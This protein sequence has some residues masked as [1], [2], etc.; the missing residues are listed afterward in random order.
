[1]E[2]IKYNNTMFGLATLECDALEYENICKNEHCYEGIPSDK[3]IKLYGDI[4][5]GGEIDGDEDYDESWTEIFIDIAKETIETTISTLNSTIIPEYCVA[6]ASSSCYTCNT[7][8]IKKWKVSIHIIVTNIVSYQKN[9]KD[10]FNLCNQTAKN[11]KQNY[12][13]DYVLNMKELFDMSVYGNN[14]KFRS[15]Y[16]SKNNEKRPLVLVEGSFNDSIISACFGDDLFELNKIVPDPEPIVNE[17][18]NIKNSLL[19]KCEEDDYNFIEMCLYNNLFIPL[20]SEY[21]PWISMGYA[22]KNTLG[23]K[24]RKLFHQFSKFSSK[25][26]ETETSNLYDKIDQSLIPQTGKLEKKKLSIASIKKWAKD[27]NPTLYQ[28]IV[29][30]LRKKNK[31]NKIVK[32]KDDL[33]F[34]RSDYTLMKEFYEYCQTKEHYFY[35]LNIKTCEFIFL[36]KENIWEIDNNNKGVY[37]YNLLSKDFTQTK[38]DL[39]HTSQL[40]LL[41][42]ELESVEYQQ[43][44]HFLKFLKIVIID[45]QTNSHKQSIMNELKFQISKPDFTNNMNSQK[46]VIPLK[47]K[48]MCRLDTVNNKNIIETFQRTH[49]DKFNYMCNVEFIEFNNNI[50]EFQEIDDYFKSLFSDDTDTLQVFLD[51]IKTSIAGYRLKNLFLLTGAKGNNG[52]STFFE[53]LKNICGNCIDTIS[54]KVIISNAGGS[55]HLNTELEKLPN[56]RVGYVCELT[57]GDTYNIPV[58]KQIIGG[59]PMNLRTLNKTDQTIYPSCNLFGLTN[60]NGNFNNDEL[61]SKRIVIFPFENEFKN[62][63][64]FIPKMKLLKD[65]LFNYII[66]K[67]RIITDVVPSQNMVKAHQEYMTQNKIDYIEE[68]IDDCYEIGDGK[69]K[70][71]EVYTHFINWCSQRKYKND[72]N[73]Q[74]KF[75]KSLKD[76]GYKCESYNGKRYYYGLSEKFNEEEPKY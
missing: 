56:I 59:D 39:L 70:T 32:N 51:V 65:Y 43:L 50:K 74:S 76:K 57:D 2:M 37:I 67:G 35:C 62:D 34:D 46:G 69:I 24:G 48:L 7:K 72:I 30:E 63:N 54:K 26:D 53:L 22:I 1:M 40:K 71:N 11:N 25:Y 28:N 52:K 47:N 45:L 66:E 55:S 4:D 13:G 12:Y 44:S 19:Q 16:S 17:T 20:A 9:I 18:I 27:E 49:L 42:L 73:S 10:F 58:I 3:L 68:F 33:N 29:T 14:Q 36:N 41:E 5:Y 75:T 23:E 31:Q 6:I 38:I 15:I 21:K 8:K 61:F 64:N 60:Q